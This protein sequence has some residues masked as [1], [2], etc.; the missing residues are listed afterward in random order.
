[1]GA[2]VFQFHLNFNPSVENRLHVRWCREKLDKGLAMA[3][4]F[5]N[6][7]WF[8]TPDAA[9]SLVSWLSE[10]G[11]VLIA[12]DEL[13]HETFQS[14]RA[15]TGLPA[16]ATAE[17]LPIALEATAP[18]WGSYVRVH[19]RHGGFES[20]VL[21]S[22]EIQAWVVRL[23]ES[24]SAPCVNGP[25]WFLWGTDWEDAPLRNARHL[26]AELLAT[27][28]SAVYDYKAARV[29]TS[30]K[31]KGS[32]LRCWAALPDG[33][34]T[35]HHQEEQQQATRKDE[36]KRG[37]PRSEEATT[38]KRT[39]TEHSKKTKKGSLDRFFTPEKKRGKLQEA[40]EAG[41]V[42]TTWACHVCTLLNDSPFDKGA[43]DGSTT[44]HP[45]CAACETLRQLS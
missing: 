34:D 8:V 38:R 14:D 35:Q 17:L 27:L 39:W 15:Q 41:V 31:R 1:M 28:P 20:R 42:S 10:A 3:V 22:T 19:R 2:V 5:R 43:S 26:T 37:R 29:A 36:E 23:R 32:L 33:S 21:P 45:R 6:R 9:K 7:D 4:E 25:V 30:V 12:A 44:F 40:P 13:R 24:L 11:I 16:G 18:S